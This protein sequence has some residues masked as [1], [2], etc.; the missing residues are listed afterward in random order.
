[1]ELKYLEEFITL[2][3]IKNYRKVAASFGISSSSLTKH[4]ILLESALSCTLF[5]R[6]TRSIELT[7][8]GAAFLPQ[9]RRIVSLWKSAVAQAQ[10]TSKSSPHLQIGLA[11]FFSQDSIVDLLAGYR[12][13]FSD[14]AVDIVEG[15]YPDLVDAVQQRTCDLVICHHFVNQQAV[16]DTLTVRPI[17]KELLSAVVPP[18]H[19]LAGR[20]SVHLEDLRRESFILY[21]ENSEIHALIIDA[22]AKRGFSPD[23]AVTDISFN[24]CIRLVS[25][26]AGISL[27]P[28]EYPLKKARKK[29]SIIPVE[30]QIPIFADILFPKEQETMSLPARQFLQFLDLSCSDFSPATPITVN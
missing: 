1:M 29:V 3:E 28:F 10:H 21:P 8:G 2:A 12:A 17:F 30:P 25:Q 7:A 5:N 26:N 19:P 15:K 22:C 4:I 16:P 9:A 27:L 14:Y 24:N 13:R 20:S 18:E 11:S 23:I 6:T